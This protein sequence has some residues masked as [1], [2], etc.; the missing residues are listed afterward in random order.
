MQSSAT[1]VG[2][3]DL[4]GHIA[5][6]VAGAVTLGR[7]D[8]SNA[9]PPYAGGATGSLLFDSG[10]FSATNLVM[11]YKS[12]INTGAQAKASATLTVSGGVFTVTSGPIILAT[13]RGTG[14]ANATLNLL[15]G[16]FHSYADILT[17]PSNCVG[18]ITL[19]GG[20]LDMTSHTIGLGAQTVTV[21]NAQS[22]TLMN[23]GG[24]NN[25]APL[26]KTGSGTLTL[27]GTNTYAGATIVSNGVLRLTG[28]RCL[29]PT[30]ELYVSTGTTCQL[31]YTGSL[32]IHALYV[33]GVQQKGTFYSYD[34]YPSL[35]SGTGI[36]Q[37]PYTGTLLRLR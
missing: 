31:D 27:D 16:T 5:S 28:G 19:G 26:V 12:G 13:Q 14:T 24:F 37:L 20:I 15:G 34:K 29:P 21:F 33:D 8:N 35:F 2:L 23:L 7:E 11:G 10:T 6:V 25:G 1:P 22:G 18:T 36:L 17:G 30:A 3:L 32:Y 4:R 9:S